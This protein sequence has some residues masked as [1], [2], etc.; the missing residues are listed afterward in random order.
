MKRQPTSNIIALSEKKKSPSSQLYTH[1]SGKE[2]KL[3]SGFEVQN[4]N[5]YILVEKGSG[6]NKEIVPKYLCRQ[7]PL[8]TKSFSNIERSQL[9]YE[10]SWKADGRLHEEVVTAGFVSTRKDIISLSD[11]SLAVNDVN[12][13]DLINFFDRLLMIND[14]PREKMVERLGHIEGG[15]IHPLY[16]KEVQILPA[17]GGEKQ[18]LEAF[19]SSG[20]IEGWINGVLKPVEAH[21]K[22]LLILL[23]SFA[24]VLLKDLNL[25]PFVIDLSGATSKGKTTVLK[26]AATVWGTD[27]LV[28]E[29]NGTAVSFERKAAFLNSFPLM[30]DDSMKADEKQLQRFVYNF[31][32]GRSKGRGSVTGSQR[33][34]TWNNLMLSTGEVPLT[35]YAERAGGAAARILP[36]KGLPFK[37]ADYEFFDELYEAMEHNHGEIGLEFIKQ[38]EERKHELL[39]KYKEYNSMF[40]KKARGNEVVSRI[41]R[42]YAA[43][44]FAGTLVMD[45]FDAPIDLG[46]LEVMFNEIMDENKAVDKPMQ[47]LEAVLTDLDSSRESIAIDNRVFHD[48]KAIYKDQTLYLLPSYLKE[49]LK[50][51][52]S[53][54]RSEWLRREISISG[55]EKGKKT[56]SR[57]L[58]HK[59]SVHRVVAIHPHVVEELGFDFNVNNHV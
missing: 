21:P 41:A 44:Y 47:M 13:R 43:I 50:T 58:R 34:F 23:A 48:L 5:L 53:S 57:T 2:F 30:L 7:V 6:E 8:I 17:D 31:S 45:F 12:A 28:S 56:D 19:E 11:Y 18:M 33:E 40:Q 20:T 29:W 52:Q 3:P 37:D 9:Y 46:W 22:A 4:N 25:G 38:W 14:I 16:S 10:L 27:H 26:T 54:I 55:L 24:S 36:V 35:E 51:E 15:F 42:H 49:F 59:G 32:G 39:P 1:A